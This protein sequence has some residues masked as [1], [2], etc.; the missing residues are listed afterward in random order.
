[1]IHALIIEGMLAIVFLITAIWAAAFVAVRFT[2]S[3]NYAHLTSLEATRNVF[4]KADRNLYSDDEVQLQQ[5][6]LKRHLERQSWIVIVSLFPWS[7]V[8]F[9]PRP[10]LPH[11]IGEA[12]LVTD[13]KRS[14]A[15]AI[16]AYLYN[17]YLIETSLR[18]G[19]N[20]RKLD[21]ELGIPREKNEGEQLDE[22]SWILSLFSLK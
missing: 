2:L 20:S 4:E 19:E 9:L 11:Q 8:F 12:N 22:R 15:F 17:T 16:G 1:M 13:R 10:E 14:G 21:G 3:N 18:S 7:I 6:A 5:R